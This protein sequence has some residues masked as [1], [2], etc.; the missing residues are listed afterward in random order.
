MIYNTEMRVQKI[1]INRIKELKEEVKLK[2]KDPRQKHKIKYKI[3]DIV[4][5][6]I[7]AVLANCNDWEEIED[8]GRYR[9]KWLRK[10]LLLTGGIPSALTYERVIA[11]LDK[12]V[13]NE[14]FVEFCK[15]V[16][17]KKRT[18]TFKDIFSFDGKVDRGS[19]RQKTM[20][21]EA[22]KPLN[23]LNVYSDTLGI[24]VAQ[25]IIEDKTNEIPMI[26]II[27]EK[28]DLTG[29]ICTWDA[30]N[31]QRENIKAVKEKGG[32]YVVALK[33]NQGTF[34]GNVKNYLN[35]ERLEIIRSGYEGS[36]LCKVEKTH[37]K[38][39][40]YEYFQTEQIKWYLGKENWEGLKSIGAVKKTIDT[41]L[42]QYVEKRYYISS[43]LRNIEMFSNSI[44]KHWNVENKLHWQLDFTFKCDSNLT[45]NKQ[46]LFNLQLIKKFALGI[47]TGVQGTYN[48]KS[49]KKI[50]NIIALNTEE[51]LEK[52]FT[53]FNGI[54]SS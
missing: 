3:W 29:V 46:A 10:S 7:L 8:F 27:I 49:L 15:R 20:Y 28:L 11:V 33:G 42:E 38:I 53:N 2:V 19:S 24:S 4:I 44:R 37:G 12:D 48:G 31:T 34:L 45:V 36:Y 50:R 41:G 35:E 18:Q 23:V 5:V 26:P 22:I 43:L 17:H 47:L 40:R 6:A 30:M 54:E 52:I 51:E 13:L 9:I 25:E 39:I 16:K 14:I 32:E 1:R 21:S